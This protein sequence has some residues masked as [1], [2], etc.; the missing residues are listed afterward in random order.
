MRDRRWDAIYDS[1]S[2]GMDTVCDKCKTRG[3]EAACN[4]REDIV[5]AGTGGDSSTCTE[6]DSRRRHSEVG[7]IVDGVG[8]SGDE[9]SSTRCTDCIPRCQSNHLLNL[10]I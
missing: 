1:S 7:D 2:Q 9:S 5:W 6:G 3:V 10:H 4:T 8:D